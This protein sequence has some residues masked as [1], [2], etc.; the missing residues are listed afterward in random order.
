[1]T[2]RIV[3]APD[4]FKGSLTA[5]QVRAA[6]AAG[7]RRVHPDASIVEVPVADGGEGTI[8]VAVASGAVDQRLPVRGPLGQPIVARWARI[9]ATAYIELAQAAGLKDI[10]APGPETAAKAST[11]GLGQIMRAAVDAGCRDLVIG[12]GGSASTDGGAGALQALGWRMLDRTGAP[13]RPGGSALRDLA[14]LHRGVLTGVTITLA[15]DVDNPLLGSRGAAEVF[16]PQKGADPP[17]VAALA[18]GLA[19][20][21]AVARLDGNLGGGGAAGGTAAGFAGLLG[22][23]LRPG[24][25]LLLDLAGF[26]AAA[27]GADLVLTGEGSLDEQSLSGKAPVGVARRAGRLRVPAVAIVGRCTVAAAATRGAGF[28]QVVSLTEEA[29]RDGRDPRR[30]AA[31]LITDVT[32]RLIQGDTAG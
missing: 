8:E 23:R 28:G 27:N 29:D 13:L 22:A 18:D 5:G 19:R 20:W 10:A 6:M 12:L 11:F 17:T 25:D 1:V 3:L 16:G 24:V 14:T 21:A 26:D 7:I 30:D 31:E 9:G 15:V 2:V 4:K 32:A